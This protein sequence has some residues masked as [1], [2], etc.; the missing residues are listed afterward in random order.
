MAA[1]AEDSVETL[2]PEVLARW[3]QQ[4][5]PENTRAFEALVTHYWRRVFAL[6]YSLMSNRQDAEDQAQEVFLKIYQRIG[7]LDDPAALTSWI[8]RI[9]TNTCYDALD[10]QQRRPS[11]V[12]FTPT[13]SDENAAQAYAAPQIQ[14]PEDAV[15]QT[16]ERRYLALTMAQLN[17]SAQQALILRDVEG[18]SY[19]EIA[20]ILSLRMSAVK[21]RIHR[22]RLAFQQAFVTTYPDFDSGTRAPARSWQ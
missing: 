7:S 17:H 19:E 6:A 1:I 14:H 8:M 20:E 12:P 18:R 21:M 10:R 11:V 16:E 22:A 15:V 9:T 4:T 3:C 2:S 5:H 13:D